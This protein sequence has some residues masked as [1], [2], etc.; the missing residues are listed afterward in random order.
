MPNIKITVAGKIATNK[1]PG[2]AIVCGNS[3]YTVTFSFD[4][5]WAALAKRTARFVYY[6]N[7]QRLYQET[8]FTGNTV[9][10][11]VLS[12]ID[13]VLVGVYA[14][15]LTTTTPAK[16]LCDR[17][18]LCGDQLE[19][20]SP[21][22]KVTLQAQIGNLDELDTAAKES[23]VAAI[24]E[25]R[26][27]AAGEITDEQVAQAV[28]AYLAEHPAS[29]GATA[30]QAA[31]IQA[32]KDAIELLQQDGDGIYILSEGETLADVPANFDVVVDPYTNPES[33]ENPEGTGGAVTDEQIAQAV[34]QYLEENPVAE[35]PAGP[36]GP[37]GE[38]GPAGPAGPQGERGETGPVGPAGP[39]GETG[40]QGPQG[41]RGE[42]GPAGP[43]GP[44]GETGEQGPQG[45][46]GYTPVRGKD[47][48]TA[49][50]VADI[51][52]QVTAGL[53]DY[54]PAVLNSDFY[55]PEFPTDAPDGRIFFKKVN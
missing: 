46:Q 8:A 12:G 21:E 43:A 14:G 10:V 7:G 40:E 2:V 36:A 33:P 48:F 3:D 20:L 55:G 26:K 38:T 35:G 24:N 5:E 13:Y 11:P 17:S 54:V 47:Y 15:N 29:A 49:A 45:A 42:T 18:I 28:A 52:A 31:Q 27:N 9:A 34:A 44:Q 51:V 16:V 1:T 39:Q 30:E 32:N 41:E 25:V 23:L 37:Q 4:N 22:Q 19:G 50:D 53:A 6:K